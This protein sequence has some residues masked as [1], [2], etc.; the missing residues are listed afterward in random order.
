MSIATVYS[1]AI[2]GIDA[3]LVTI[4]VHISNGLPSLSIVGMLETAVKESKDRVRS[5]LLN[6]QFSF[7]QQ[8]I[9]INLAPA[10]LPKEGGRFD[11]PIALGILAAS[12]QLPLSSLANKEFIGEL[13]LTG[14]LR[15]VRGVLPSI[16]AATQANNELIL[17]LV[18]VDE[19][20]LI[21]GA[22]SYGASHLLEVCAHLFGQKHLLMSVNQQAKPE[23]NYPDLAD[24]R[25]QSHARRALEIAAAGSHS[26][27]FNGPPGTGKTMLASRLPS[28]LPAM[29]EQEAVETATVHSISTQGFK[30]EQWRQRPFRSPHHTASAVAMVGGGSQPRPGEI[31]LAHNGVLFL[32]EL[33]EFDRKVLEVLREPIESG[34]ITIS[35]AANQAE[36]PARFQLIAAMNP[37]PCGYLGE[38]R[39]HCTEDQVRRYRAKVSGPLMDRI[40]MLVE[41]PPVAHLTL[42]PAPENKKEEDSATVCKRVL[43]AH[44]RQM[45]RAGKPN[46]MLENKELDAYC[47]LSESNYQLLEHAISRFGLSARAY[48]RILKVARTIADLA[49]SDQIQT[50]H[51]SEAIGYRRLDT[52]NT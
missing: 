19:A 39:C 38:S 40:D 52:R 13:G 29:T 45:E 51:L 35:R 24:V 14:E 28:I 16:L 12:N 23:V 43:Q 42:R 21:D 3:P 4:E 33:P 9:T 31:S 26:L 27:I 32:D 30:V 49:N 22:T 20:A 48:H 50:A 34:K 15:A 36:F 18:N 37:C 25:G 11:L 7:P 2:T 1:R 44:K 5:A 8:R 6:S 41:V 17:P 47:I 10:D 46:T